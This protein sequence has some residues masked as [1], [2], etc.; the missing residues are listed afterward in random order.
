[1]LQV[2]GDPRAVMQLLPAGRLQ[3]QF[4]GK[5]KIVRFRGA[6]FAGDLRS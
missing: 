6:A 4:R 3:E 1:M 5:E 2:I